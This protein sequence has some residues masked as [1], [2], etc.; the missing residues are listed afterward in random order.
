M[1]P[2]SPTVNEEG[3]TCVNQLL[4]VVFLH[5]KLSNTPEDESL[6]STGSKADMIEYCEGWTPMVQTLLSLVLGGEVVEWTLDTHQPLST[7]TISSVALIGDA[8]HPM[9][10]YG[11]ISL[12]GPRNA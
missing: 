2:I 5:P 10:P 9:L 11:V 8:C 7:W 12:T 4:N 1:Y 3:G 6:T